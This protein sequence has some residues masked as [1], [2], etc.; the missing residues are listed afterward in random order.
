MTPA[1]DHARPA[2]VTDP[3]PTPSTPRR[4]ARS[5]EAP[6]APWGDFP[7]GEMCI[8]AGIVLIVWGALSSGAQQG[9]LI[10][11]GV[12]LVCLAALELVIREHLAGFRSHTTLLAGTVAVAVMAPL[13]FAGAVRGVVIVAGAL[14]GALAFGVLR[15]VFMRRAHG[16]G[17]RA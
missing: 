14:A 3:A 4:K 6:A 11:G 2:I 9:V 16:L 5:E 1:G 7:L 10:S 17:F 13:Y 12:V 8:F 15:K